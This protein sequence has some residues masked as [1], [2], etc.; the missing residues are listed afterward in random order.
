MKDE[1]RD[2]REVDMDVRDS[3]VEAVA[4]LIESLQHEKPDDRSEESRMYAIAITD[5]QKLQAWIFQL[6]PYVH[7]EESTKPQSD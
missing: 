6:P 3:A 4:N 2:E 1:T 7:V 5:A